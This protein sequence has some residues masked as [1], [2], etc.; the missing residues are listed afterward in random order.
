MSYEKRIREARPRMS[1]SF[2]RLADHILDSYIQAALMTAT[3]IAHQVDV[4]AATVV[5][6]AQTLGY[7]GFPELQR[8][9]KD[10]VKR[11]LLIRPQEAAEP[12]SIPGVVETSLERLR[13]AVEQARKLIDTDAVNELV[14]KIGS[15]RRIII[16][17]EALGQAAAYNLFNLLEQGGFLV[18]VIE[19]GVTDLARTVSTAVP[20][21][22]LLAIDVAG[23]APFIARALQEARK[24]GIPTA[25][26]AGAA[27][28]ESAHAAE[29]VLAAQNQ[30]DIG[31]GIVVVDAVVYALAE[32]LRWRFSE[33]FTDADKSIEEMYQRIQ[34]GGD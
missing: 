1:K 19:H 4:D 21:D 15:S 25:V 31:I 22:L 24:L 26:I 13:D 27:S 20:E 2:L 16:V 33:R 7:R 23:A 9:I 12:D 32:A 29:V 18:T 5:R 14:D 17:P 6:F 28:L 3:E 34:F 30:P 10:R 11:D 8:E